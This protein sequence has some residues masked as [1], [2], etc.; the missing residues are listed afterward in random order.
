MLKKNITL[1]AASNNPKCPLSTIS[2]KLYE[3]NTTDNNQ[4]MTILN[5]E[6]IDGIFW[7]LM[8]KK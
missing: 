5:T 2:K 6:K 8:K 7:V 3:I 1:F 4:L